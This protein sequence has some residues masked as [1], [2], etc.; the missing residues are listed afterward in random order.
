MAAGEALGGRPHIWASRIE[1]AQAVNIGLR[2]ASRAQR[3]Y[4]SGQSAPP[5]GIPPHPNGQLGCVLGTSRAH[6][7]RQTLR[8][9]LGL[10]S[11]HLN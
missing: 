6:K 7:L 4:M 11:I 2:W 8:I 5:L 3:G 1:D 9:V 10:P